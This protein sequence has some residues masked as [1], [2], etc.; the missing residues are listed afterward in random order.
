MITLFFAA[1]GLWLSYRVVQALRTGAA[2]VEL[3]LVH[4][5]R[6]PAYYWTIVLIQ[7]ALATTCLLTVARM[8]SR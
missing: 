6:R 7:A 3:D 8:L 5:A 1:L 4:R 2:T